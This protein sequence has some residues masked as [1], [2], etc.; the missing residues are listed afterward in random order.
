MVTGVV[1][2][3]ESLLDVTVPTFTDAPGKTLDRDLAPQQIEEE[4]QPGSVPKEKPDMGGMIHG[5]SSP[6]NTGASG[7]STVTKIE[8]RYSFPSSTSASPGPI[9]PGLRAPGQS[10]ATTM[11]NTISAPPLQA[12]R[13]KRSPA[14]QTEKRAAKTGSRV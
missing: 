13:D 1:A 9:S 8:A 7:L 11:P 12:N 10:S 14:S 4:Q 2:M 3:I 6:T 5:H